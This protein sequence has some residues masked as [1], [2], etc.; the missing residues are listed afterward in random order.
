MASPAEPSI[1]TMELVPT[2][3]MPATINTR[4]I[5]YAK[6]A[7]DIPNFCMLT[8]TS[9]RSIALLVILSSPLTILLPIKNTIKANTSVLKKFKRGSLCA[10]IYCII[11][12]V[13]SSLETSEF[14]T[15]PT[16][17]SS[18]SL[19]A[20]EVISSIESRHMLYILD[21]NAIATCLS[22]ASARLY[23]HAAPYTHAKRRHFN[24]Y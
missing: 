4:R 3:S 17:S 23:R 18:I 12:L 5:L 2:P 6:P 9:L 15:F 14:I 8:S 24:Y 7:N 16:S 1:A 20:I 11:K 13:F 22:A 19:P 21:N 10:S